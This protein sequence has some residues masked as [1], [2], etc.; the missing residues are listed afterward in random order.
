[1]RLCVPKEYLDR[2]EKESVI[3]VGKDLGIELKMKYGIG[4][5]MLSEFYH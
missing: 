1:M 3:E 4:W 5:D 2:Y